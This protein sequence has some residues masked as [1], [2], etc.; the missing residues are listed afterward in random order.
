MGTG[1]AAPQPGAQGFGHF[2]PFCARVSGV[3]R[4]QTMQPL[5]S[6]FPRQI[7]PRQAGWPRRH[8]AG[9]RFLPLSGEAPGQKAAAEL[10]G[11]VPALPTTACSENNPLPAPLRD[12][13]E[14]GGMLGTMVLKG[15]TR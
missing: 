13:G 6:T 5:Q 3:Y 1:R 7:G 2:L 14:Q 11:G 9:A 4:P 8:A 15:P 10:T 12:G